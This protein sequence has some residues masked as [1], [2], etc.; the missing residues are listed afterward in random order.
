MQAELIEI[1]KYLSVLL[2]QP[3]LL[4]C[5]SSKQLL[6]LVFVSCANS[7]QISQIQLPNFSVIATRSAILVFYVYLRILILMLNQLIFL[8]RCNENYLQI[9]IDRI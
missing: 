9:R 7:L 8:F 4:M 5:G 2:A 6:V 3:R 1:Q